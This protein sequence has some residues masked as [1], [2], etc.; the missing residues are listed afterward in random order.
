MLKSILEEFLSLEGVAA[1][2]LVGRDGFV[3]EIA[4]ANSVDTDALGALTSSAMRFYDA[5]GDSMGM[6]PL[7]QLV[8]EYNDGALILTPV[9]ASEFL[10]LLSETRSA[11][12]RL[13][14]EVARASERVAAAL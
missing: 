9:T 7:K 13:T 1:A 5:S 11:T 3:I 12:G 14:Y 8:M 4:T 10:A 6:G 2:A